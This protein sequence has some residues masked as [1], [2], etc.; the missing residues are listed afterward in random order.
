MNTPRPNC[1]PTAELPCQTLTLRFAQG[2]LPPARVLTLL[3]GALTLLAYAGNAHADCLF[4]FQ[5]G[6]WSNPA[7]WSYPDGGP[8]S[9]GDNA[10]IYG[11]VAY[12]TMPGAVCKNLDVRQ[13]TLSISGAGELSVSGGESYGYWSDGTGV[14]SGG[15][16]TVGGALNLGVT[17]GYYA[18]YQ[19]S[20]GQLTAS[21]ENLCWSTFT[22][23]GGS[24]TVTSQFCLGAIAVSAYL[25]SGSGQL[26]A[27]VEYV[28]YSQYVGE[29]GTGV[30]TQSG[31]TNTVTD[32]L[33]VGYVYGSGGTYQLSGAGQ[34]TVGNAVRVGSDSG[35]G[36]LEWLGG[37]L[38]T[39]S[40]VLGAKGTLAIGF[41]FAMGALLNGSLYQG[42][43]L[44]GLNLAT[45]EVSHGATATQDVASQTLSGLQLGSGAGAGPFCSAAGRFRPES[46][47]RVLTH[48]GQSTETLIF[49]P[50][51]ANS[52]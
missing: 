48:P 28:G 26:A 2:L 47:I 27:P 34:L 45:L 38:T 46:P 33:C 12:V 24:N 9:S 52:W 43:S 7:C 44:T 11:S 22:Q 4:Q 29:P 39:P 25:L 6:D 10:T 49:A 50:R 41:D 32:Q 17:S 18:T 3:A 37:S 35:T 19:L 23:T 16:H 5:T 36:R 15:R 51:C 20:G 40:L 42:S 8:P 31:G 30:F 14:Q 13:A 1:T 21:T